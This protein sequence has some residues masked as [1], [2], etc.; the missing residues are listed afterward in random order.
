MPSLFSVVAY[1]VAT[2][3]AVLGLYT[4]FAPPIILRIAAGDRFEHG[5]WSLGK[6]DTWVS[7]LAVPGSA[8]CACCS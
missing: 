2:S 1:L 6:H 7:P 4:A 3:I 8:R 5:A